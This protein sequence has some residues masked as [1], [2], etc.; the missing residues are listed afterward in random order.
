MFQGSVTVGWSIVISLFVS[1]ECPGHSR[2]TV[3]LLSPFVMLQF[4]IF[5][6]IFSFFYD[7]HVLIFILISQCNYHIFILSRLYIFEYP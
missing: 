5:S 4:G 7:D 2:T 3:L 6:V 1:V